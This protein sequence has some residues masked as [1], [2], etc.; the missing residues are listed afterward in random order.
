MKEPEAGLRGARGRGEG[1]GLRIQ[2]QIIGERSPGASQP[3]GSRSCSFWEP[4]S[5]CPRWRT[6]NS[7]SGVP[8]LVPSPQA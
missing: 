7:P 6:S 4:L 5:L 3:R 1:V 2:N 8:R